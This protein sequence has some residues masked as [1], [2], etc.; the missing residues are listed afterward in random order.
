MLDGLP[1]GV[2]GKVI[3]RI[4]LLK[5]GGPT[6]DYPYTSQI[7]GKFREARLR[8]GKTRYRVLYF[9]DEKRT[10]I[11]LHGFTKDTG[12]VEESD[13]RVGRE[14]AGYETRSAAWQ[15]VTKIRETETSQG[16]EKEMKTAWDSY[17]KQELKKPEVRRAYEEETKVLSIGLELAN[18][19]K[20]KGMT[21]AE[22]ARKIGTSAPQLSRTER[23]PENVNMRTL[24]RYA[25]AVGMDLD[26]RLV[27]KG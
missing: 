3:A 6:L 1:E 20:R 24:M 25:E 15:T 10:A 9:F 7:E 22:V 19:R 18:Q 21:Q 2:R 5:K 23:R 13:K 14:R 8:V 4:D 27:A 26:I 12:S 16:S 11:L 17:V